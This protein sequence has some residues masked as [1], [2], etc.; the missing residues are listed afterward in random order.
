MEE[1]G[2]GDSAANGEEKCALTGDTGV[3][4]DVDF[5]PRIGFFEQREDF[6]AEGA[7]AEASAQTSVHFDAATSHPLGREGLFEQD[8]ARAFGDVGS[9]DARGALADGIVERGKCELSDVEAAFAQDKDACVGITLPFDDRGRS[10]NAFHGTDHQAHFLA[11]GFFVEVNAPVGGAGS[12]C[13]TDV[14]GSGF[15]EVFAAQFEI[16][17]L[18]AFKVG[19]VIFFCG[20][21]EIDDRK[22]AWLSVDGQ[23]WAVD[24]S[25]DLDGFGFGFGDNLLT[26]EDFLDA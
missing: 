20:D 14:K 2:D 17:A 6:F 23:A 13:N 9:E 25:C 7:V 1:V 22:R 5:E 16:D 18:F 12:F 19:D 24:A 11:L 15:G 26:Q 21:R 3:V 8:L 4:V 10:A